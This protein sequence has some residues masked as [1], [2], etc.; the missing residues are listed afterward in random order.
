MKRSDVTFAGLLGLA[1]CASPGHDDAG[2]GNVLSVNNGS[3]SGSGGD[4]VGGSGPVPVASIPAVIRDFK[5]YDLFDLTTDPDFENPPFGIG[6]SGQPSSGYLGP[7]DDH[8]IVADALGPG[9]KPVYKNSGTRTLTTH[10]QAAF[11]KWFND[12]PGTNYRVTYPL[13]LTQNQGGPLQHDS[14]QQGVPYGPTVPDPGN[15]FFPIDDGSPHATPFGNEGRAHNYSFTVEIHTVFTYKGGEQF[16][17]RGD[18]DVFVF[19]D[20]KLVINL[21][22]VHGPEPMQVNIDSLGL[23]KGQTYPLDFFSAERH[24]TGSNIE[25]QT[26]LDLKPAPV[27]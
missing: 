24:V 19:V 14:E 8:D 27:K 5:F 6:Q 13:P 11:D 16:S 7:W 15:G 1:A 18:D 25:F 23:T 12:V 4:L 9:G 22:G 20:G 17:F 26:T 3:N 10:G 21:G 2:G